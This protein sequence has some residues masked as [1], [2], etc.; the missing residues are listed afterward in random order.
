MYF[1][2]SFIFNTHDFHVFISGLLCHMSTVSCVVFLKLKNSSTCVSHYNRRLHVTSPER[3]RC[4]R[5]TEHAEFSLFF[6]RAHVY[7]YALMSYE[8]CTQCQAIRGLTE[9]FIQL[10]LSLMLCPDSSDLLVPSFPLNIINREW[11]IVLFYF[12][13]AVKHR[14]R[15]VYIILL[16]FHNERSY[17]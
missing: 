5:L 8:K 3:Q 15:V 6:G 10:C 13:C 2:Y 17:S 11:E 1:G 4:A 7:C 9:H 12:F 16:Q 14:A